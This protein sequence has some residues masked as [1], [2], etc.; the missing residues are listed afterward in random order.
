M[1]RKL[2]GKSIGIKLKSDG[3]LD[4][5]KVIFLVFLPSKHDHEQVLKH[6][7]LKC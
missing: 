3:T 5:A 6:K 4:L 7:C 1:T 2:I